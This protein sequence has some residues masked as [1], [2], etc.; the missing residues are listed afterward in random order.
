MSTP[1]S[2]Y[3]YNNYREFL[4]DW[5]Q[6]H[7]LTYRDFALRYRDFISF[8]ALAKLLSHA[9]SAQRS[10]GA[11]RISPEALA[12]LGKAMGL[13]SDELEYLILLRLENDAARVDGQFGD[14]YQK[15]LS[16]LS[17]NAKRQTAK[18]LSIKRREGK[19]NHSQTSSKI[20]ELIDVFPSR[21]RQKLLEEALLQG[22]IYA[23]RQSGKPG[24]RS[25]LS[26]LEELAQLKELGAP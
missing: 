23:A 1:K 11:Y 19:G 26:L 5:L 24:V 9:K 16:N 8:I 17:N 15:I 22:K 13:K 4:V 3:S 25:T 10:E 21:M 14:A 2:I 20:A 7:D 18:K 6:A 12:R